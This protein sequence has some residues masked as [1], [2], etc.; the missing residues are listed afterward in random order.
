M[1]CRSHRQ[2][3]TKNVYQKTTKQPNYVVKEG[4]LSKELRLEQD[5]RGTVPVGVAVWRIKDDA[6]VQ[7]WMG[8]CWLD[9]DR[10]GE[11]ESK[12]VFSIFAQFEQSPVAVG[13]VVGKCKTSHQKDNDQKGPPRIIGPQ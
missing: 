8:V 3:L 5:C 7:R 2:T 4:S 13:K 1:L 12:I 11:G 9:L 10:L 6:S